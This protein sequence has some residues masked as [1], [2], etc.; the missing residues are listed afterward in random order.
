MRHNIFRL[1]EIKN[2]LLNHVLDILH[3]IMKERNGHKKLLACIQNDLWMGPNS[4]WFDKKKKKII[5][6][7]KPKNRPLCGKDVYKLYPYCAISFDTP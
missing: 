5:K 6:K 7:N 3:E 2:N 4:F 1:A